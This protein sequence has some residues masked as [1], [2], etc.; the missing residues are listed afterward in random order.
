MKWYQEEPAL[1]F[2]DVLLV[3]NYSCV[4][5]MEVD[6]G[7]RLTRSIRLNVPICSAAMDTVTESQMAIAIATEGGIG[8]VHKNMSI[9]KQA[10]EVKK[11]KRSANGVIPDPMTL[12]PDTTVH[13]AYKIMEEAGVSGFPI[14]ENGLVKG[15]LTTRDIHF[16]TDHSIKVGHLMTQGRLVTAPPDTTLD[17]AREIL[18]ANKVEKL[19]LVDKAG[20]LKGLIT[21][22][23]I[24]NL[25]K[26]P[27]A[28]R[29][30]AG[31]LIVGAAVGVG[32]EERVEA[33]IE[34]NVD[35][36]CIDTAHGH[37][38][39]VLESL[40]SIKKRFGI[41]V[42]VGNI[43]TRDAAEDLIKAGADAL[44]VGI[45][46]GSICTTRVVTGVGVP[47]LAAIDDVCEV[48]NQTGIPVIADGGIKYSGDITKALAAGASSV[49]IG[50]LLAGVT[51][52]PGGIVYY[53]G[54]QYKD[55][56]GMGSMG[57]MVQG[58]KDRYGQR[59]VTQTSKLVPEGIEARVPYK[60]DLNAYLHQ[61]SGGLRA[62]MGYCG[63][64]TLDELRQKARF[65]RTTSAG[66]HEN[67]PH[68]VKI[69]KEAPNY[70][71]EI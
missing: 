13:E 11:V 59:G 25:D 67:H 5:P 61:L 33:L 43:A 62:G 55:Y 40:K 36:I 57:A 42:V 37:S 12:S 58:S 45:G 4:L 53:Q 56:R 47:Q 18:R 23:D 26:Y 71:A 52:S 46:P 35:V 66:L 8:F 21:M 69:A 30:L 2:D 22:R 39:G 65:V 29:D 34:A 49:M 28:N 19:L 41:E 1:T 50:S 48:A 17:Q 16:E 27:L 31:R 20:R 3:P 10:Q 7:T 44:K 51:E 54:R 32:E 38:R 63:A 15:I 9:E 6:L 64:N 70:R 14:I 60:G 24:R 68:D